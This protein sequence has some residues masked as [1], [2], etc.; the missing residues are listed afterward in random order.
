[1]TVDPAALKYVSQAPG[2]EVDLNNGVKATV[3]PMVDSRMGEKRVAVKIGGE[4][5]RQMDSRV[6][7]GLTGM[8][9]GLDA[10]SEGLLVHSRLADRIEDTARLF[11]PETINATL[12][13]LDQMTSMWKMM[14]LFHPSWPV[15]NLIGNGTLALAAGARPQHMADPKRWRQI[16][17]VVRGVTN[18]DF[19][20][21]LRISAGGIEYSGDEFRNLLIEHKAINNNLSSETV[22]QAMRRAPGMAAVPERYM[23]RFLG[24]W[25]R[26]NQMSDDVLRGLAFWSF[27]DQGN[28]V[29]GSERKMLDG[30]FDFADFTEVERN[31]FRRVVPFYSWMRSN[32]GYQINMLMERPGYAALAPKIKAAMEES[33]AGESVVPEEMRPGWMRDSLATQIGKDKD[34]RFAVM[35]GNGVLPQTDV[36][37]IMAPLVGTD[38]ALKF[39]HYL[40]SGINPVIS[41]PLQLGSGLEFF[42]GRTIGSDLTSDL[43]VGEFLGNQVRPVAEVGRV[44]RALERSPAEG[45]AR[46][47]V[48]GRVQ[49][50]DE[51]RVESSRER[52][53]REEEVA[54]RSAVRRAERLGESSLEARA[55]LLKHYEKMGKLGFDAP[56]WA[57]EQLQ[58]S[59]IT[60]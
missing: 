3:A 54:L 8:M 22:A 56:R 18:P 35:L 13:T 36:F 37:N 30:M 9:T 28:T 32:L 41:L 10:S 60:G 23:R 24:P 33:I 44:G 25:M 26:A 15:F 4:T 20:K 53:L 14:T 45:A 7:S 46:A 55:R 17:R 38:G 43:S 58:A 59:P 57:E 1:M 50:F 11:D 47:V 29:L 40:T 2:R 39:I 21:D 19:L 42:S 52:E 51:Q 16:V 12:G 5:Y 34:S 31:V 6:W 48:G 27:L 49:A